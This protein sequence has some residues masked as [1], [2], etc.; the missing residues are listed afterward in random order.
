MNL[1]LR[2]MKKQF[3]IV[4]LLLFSFISFGQSD[5]L[6]AHEWGTFTTTHSASGYQLNLYASFGDQLP[7]F[8]G[9]RHFKYWTYGKID[10]RE[11]KYAVNSYYK[12][13]NMRMETPVLYFYSKKALSAKVQ[14]L[15]K[16]GSITEFYPLPSKVEDDFSPVKNGQMY[17][18]NYQGECLWDIDILDKDQN[19][20]LTYPDSTVSNVWSAP[21]QVGANLI[22]SGTTRE[23]YIFYRGIAHF[24][25]PI[26]CSN[27]LNRQVGIENTLEQA[28]PMVVCT[29]LIHGE[30]KVHYYG[31]LKGNSCITF[32]RD[33]VYQENAVDLL[34]QA[35]IKQ[36]L[37][38]DE[39]QAMMNTWKEDYFKTPGLKIF[40][41]VPKKLIDEILPLTISPMPDKVERVYIGRIEMEDAA[42]E[43]YFN[44]L[45]SSELLNFKSQDKRLEAV[46]RMLYNSKYKGEPRWPEVLNSVACAPSASVD[47]V[48]NSNDIQIYP[49]PGSGI[50]QMRYKQDWENIESI[51]VLNIQGQTIV[52]DLKKT[53]VVD[54]IL[55]LDLS[56][57]TNGVYF[58]AFKHKGGRVVKKI[59]LTGSN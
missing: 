42:Q 27:S 3:L 11:G 47:P 25:N 28:I 17:F 45:T 52:S 22:K 9:H 41:I 32:S 10:G 19:E 36:G 8:V 23:K 49:N 12:D 53:D 58:V 2:T 43:Q 59:I 33:S 7:S 31:Q 35:L 15:F 29:E 54:G 13:G 4:C 5:D 46:V 26:K 55:R 24:N 20:T 37:Y 44:G 18:E 1:F 14:V 6:V 16:N 38:E 30:V 51:S 57:H 50:Y 56:G 40:W 34:K 39:A 21:R 48:L